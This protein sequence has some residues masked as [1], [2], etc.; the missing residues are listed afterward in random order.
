M[1][2]T[3]PS[4]KSNQTSATTAPPEVMEPSKT[5]K[6]VDAVKR[7]AGQ[8]KESAVKSG[9]SAL[10]KGKN[11]VAESVGAYRAALADAASHMEETNH[12][13]AA[14]G[15]H[16]IAD[17]VGQVEN[18]LRTADAGRLVDDAEECLRSHPAVSFASLFCGGMALGRFLRAGRPATRTQRAPSGTSAATSQATPT[19]QYA[20]RA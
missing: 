7:E 3:N 4:Q 20:G 13:L 15:A 11:Q 5:S 2:E 12:A 8:V 9:Q 6:V 14:K 16:R 10:E 18:Y 19:S 1:N 17:S